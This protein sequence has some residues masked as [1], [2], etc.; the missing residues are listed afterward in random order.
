VSNKSKKQTRANWRY[1]IIGGLGCLVFNLVNQVNGQELNSSPASSQPTA[2]TSQSATVAAGSQSS[3]S[4]ATAHP[5]VDSKTTD[6]DIQ[7]VTGLSIEQLLNVTV[8]SAS[9]KEQKLSD[10]PAAMTVLNADDIR[11]SGATTLPDLLRYV[12]GVQVGAV[13]NSNTS[14]TIRGF[15]NAYASKLLVLIDGRSI[16]D[17]LFG[18]VDWQYQKIMMENI[19]RVEVIRGPGATVWG[20][21][22][23]NGV[24][25]II[26]KD[27]KDAQGGQVGA[28]LGTKDQGTG[29][30]RYGFKPAKDMDM[31]VYGQ[32]INEASTTPHQANIGSYDGDQDYL[33]GFRTDYRPNAD[34][35]F[36][37]S[38]DYASTKTE[39]AR[40]DSLT[41]YRTL[42][43]P[44]IHEMGDADNV[45]FVWEHNIE[46]DNQVTLQSYFD[47][48]T[49]SS[50]PSGYYASDSVNTYDVQVR[51]TLPIE[52]LSTMKQELTYG[53]EYKDVSAHMSDNDYATWTR[54]NVGNQTVSLFAQTDMHIIDDV[55]TL[56]AG[57]KYDHNDYSGNEVQPSVRLLYKVDDRNSLWWSVSHAVREPAVVD[58][59]LVTP[60]AGNPGLKS[61]ELNAYEMG[62][63][64]Q[65]EQWLSF[66]IATY[67]N[68]YNHLIETY[69]PPGSI[70]PTFEQFQKAQIY[71]IEPSFKA[72]VQSWWMFSGSYSLCKFHSDD[73]SVPGN[74]TY[75][76]G[77]PL[78]A[79]DPQN[80]ISLRSSF[81][82]P[83]NI[84][85]DLGGRFVDKI[86]SANGYFVG[87]VRVGW[88]P[89]DNWELSIVGQNLFMADHIEN[90]G[91]YGNATYVG[92]EVYGK[93][94]YKF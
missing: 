94:V 47:H 16:Y 10:V 8:T 40:F 41:S 50:E 71:G 81:D 9:Q 22:A 67:Y 51:H 2:S 54:H 26:T 21:N 20:A 73:T 58:S 14:V 86:A 19:E 36:R 7:A 38:S 44:L 75:A 11:R 60:A 13:N 46:T 24:I 23:V 65:P 52:L 6:S 3:P 53:V 88:R 42:S 84:E 30:F 59:W 70:Q 91:V 69:L 57:S 85:I 27:A 74:Y 31:Y 61:E 82:L 48:F 55:L 89:T 12:P 77:T 72:Q 93:V 49:R 66:D 68:D 18:G 29:N 79:T 39:D 56:T 5:P 45:N 34:D 83:E 76:G 15:S 64:V 37:L 28:I 62:Y 4:N 78:N 92:P 90:P 25:N 33:G 63:R 1:L 87:D 80:L 35:H 17:P 32:G 43:S